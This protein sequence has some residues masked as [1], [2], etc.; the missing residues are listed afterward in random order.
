MKAWINKYIIHLSFG[1]LV[2]NGLMLGLGRLIS[3]N[4]GDIF[5]SIFLWGLV[6]QFITAFM[7]LLCLITG[8]I[9]EKKTYR[10]SSLFVVLNIILAG[11]LFVIVATRC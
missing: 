10:W 2:F 6:F 5:G 9:T 11:A 8:V 4:I 3:G 7:I 1:I